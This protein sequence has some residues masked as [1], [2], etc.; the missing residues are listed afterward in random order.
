MFQSVSLGKKNKLKLSIHRWYDP[1]HVTYPR[2][3]K[4]ATNI[5][6]QIQSSCRVKGQEQTNQLC[7][8]IP[9]MNIPERKLRE[10]FCL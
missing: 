6:K 1:V 4:K 10:Q 9:A 7:F 3:H 8:Y 2:I 5:Q